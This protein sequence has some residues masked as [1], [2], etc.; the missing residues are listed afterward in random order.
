[1]HRGS[2]VESYVQVAWG[3]APAAD[4]GRARSRSSSAV[5][6]CVLEQEARYHA[7]QIL[8]PS[9]E[10]VEDLSPHSFAGASAGGFA[11]FQLTASVGSSTISRHQHLMVE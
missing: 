2:E 3:A 7:K 10:L 5:R 6:S 11:S 9:L 1:M 8:E 4:H